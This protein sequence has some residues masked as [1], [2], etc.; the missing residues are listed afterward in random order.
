MAVRMRGFAISPPATI[1]PGL[2]APAIRACR[3]R[4]SGARSPG[5][6][7]TGGCPRKGWCLV[8]WEREKAMRADPSPA[9]IGC[10]DLQCCTPTVQSGA[11]RA[12]R[13]ICRR[14]VCRPS[15]LRASKKIYGDDVNST[16]CDK[17]VKGLGN[18]A[19]DRC[20]DDDLSGASLAAMSSCLEFSTTQ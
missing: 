14:E 19:L 17:G 3:R 13:S 4:G 11:V 20:K 7:R 10:S 5:R 8:C 6:R 15:I 12:S 9:R 18:G 16:L 1:R 2:D